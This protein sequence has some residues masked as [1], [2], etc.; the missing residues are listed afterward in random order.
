ME[1]ILNKILNEIGSL[2]GD[3]GELKQGQQ[4]ID[5]ALKAVVEQTG[6]LLEFRSEVNKSLEQIMQ[7]QDKYEG[8]VELLAGELGK[9]KLE[10]E[11]LK[12]KC[13]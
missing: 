5:K 9:Q 7:K 3:V 13:S 2:R 12:R 10:I 4:R 8:D 6:G 1:K 11:R